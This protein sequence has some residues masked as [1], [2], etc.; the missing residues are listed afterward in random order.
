MTTD[1]TKQNVH[2]SGTGCG[3]IAVMEWIEANGCPRLNHT[4]FMEGNLDVLMVSSYTDTL[5]RELDQAGKI[6]WVELN[7]NGKKAYR[8]HEGFWWIFK[9]DDNYYFA[10]A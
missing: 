5:Y 7:I 10:T 3:T 8:H 2:L 4:N 9:I 1:Y 6:K